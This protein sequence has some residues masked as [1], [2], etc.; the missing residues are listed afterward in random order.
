MNSPM[1]ERIIAVAKVFPV[2]HSGIEAGIVFAGDIFDLAHV[3]S[4]CDLLK[5]LDPLRVNVLVFGVVYQV[6]GEEAQ[7]WTIRQSIHHFY[8][9]LECL[10]AQRV[11][12]AIESH[13]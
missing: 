9:A 6:T 10:S 8:R 13:V 7:L 2:D 4:A 3:H 12:W 1:V 5:L 11:R